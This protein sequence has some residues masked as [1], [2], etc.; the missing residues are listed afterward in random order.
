MANSNSHLPSDTDNPV[1]KRWQK[2]M[3]AH[4]E[5]QL[6]TL[7]AGC[8]WGVQH[9]LR[10]IPGVFGTCAGYAGGKLVDPRYQ[11]VKTGQTGH[12]EVVQ[13]LFDPKVLSFTKLLE[14]FWRLHDP[15]EV[16]RQG[17]DM[18]TQYRTVIFY[19]SDEQR[20]QAQASKDQ[21]NSRNLFGG[22]PIATLI[23]PVP[24]FFPAEEY[25]QDYYQNHGGEVCHFFRDY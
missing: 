19:H 13:I 10:S 21:L 18:G 1:G 20:E 14:S 5:G 24:T 7:G 16:D 4:P 6:V 23:Q 2:K 12:A 22:R 17:V 15:T 3:A 9:L 8:F 25:H 11:Q